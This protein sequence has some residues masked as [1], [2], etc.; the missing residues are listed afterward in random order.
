M[1]N[2]Y[3]EPTLVT[4]YIKLNFGEFRTPIRVEL[5]FEEYIYA[6]VT[7]WDT[8]E[9]VQIKKSEIPEDIWPLLHPGKRLHALAHLNAE[10]AEDLKIRGWEKD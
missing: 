5:V 7:G 6:V 2:I 10:K 3:V 9:M 1:S 8:R 4:E